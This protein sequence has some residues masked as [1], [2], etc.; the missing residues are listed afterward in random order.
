MTG[1]LAG[2]ICLLIIVGFCV[3]EVILERRGDKD[4]DE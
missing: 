2:V 3:A 4:D 1:V